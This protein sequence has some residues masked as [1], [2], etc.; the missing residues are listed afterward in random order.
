MQRVGGDGG[1]MLAWVKEKVKKP[2]GVREQS[3]KLKIWKSSFLEWGEVGRWAL[4]TGGPELC[5]C[6]CGFLHAQNATVQKL[7]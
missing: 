4:T 2:T 6:P 5:N 3:W 7:Q 1:C